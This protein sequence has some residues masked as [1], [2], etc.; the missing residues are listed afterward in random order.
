MAQTHAEKALKEKPISGTA[1]FVNGDFLKDDF[2]KELGVEDGL[3][4]VYDYTVRI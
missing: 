2:V 3:D 4:F 1:T